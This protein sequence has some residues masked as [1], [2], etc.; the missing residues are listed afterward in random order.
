[1]TIFLWCIWESVL[2]KYSGKVLGKLLLSEDREE[3]KRT[4][5]IRFAT[6]RIMESSRKRVPLMIFHE[7]SRFA[8]LR[9]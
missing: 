2:G 6:W 3:V 8:Y 9:S 4:F 7:R 5:A 1:M